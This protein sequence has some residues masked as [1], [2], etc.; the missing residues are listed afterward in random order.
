MKKL[1]VLLSVLLF[2][3]IA[4][5]ESITIKCN[6]SDDIKGINLFNINQTIELDEDS[7]LNTGVFVMDVDLNL[8]TIKA[9][10]N[11]QSTPRTITT[12]MFIKKVNLSTSKKPFYVI[13]LKSDSSDVYLPVWGKFTTGPSVLSSYVSL[14]SGYFRANCNLVK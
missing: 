14:K 8:N 11:P 7:N 9:S 13:V 2:S 5:A 6:A 12:D 4:M 1:L 3:Q 10:H